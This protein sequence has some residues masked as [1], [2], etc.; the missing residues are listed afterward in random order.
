MFFGWFLPLDVKV[1]HLR[2]ISP[3]ETANE[4]AKTGDGELRFHGVDAEAESWEGF[5]GFVWTS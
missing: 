4:A 3:Q 2:L 5:V 1:R